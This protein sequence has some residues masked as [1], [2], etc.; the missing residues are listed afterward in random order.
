MLGLKERYPIAIDIA[1]QNIYAA[2][3]QET[4]QGI[5]V[6]ELFYRKLDNGQTDSTEPDDALVPVLKEIAKNKRFRGKS[7]AIHLPAQHVY[8]FPITFEIGAEETLE[9]A[10]VRECRRH[11]SFPLEEAVVDYPSIVDI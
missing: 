5:A 3:F 9:D 10:I 7:V 6:R 2:Q 8:S 11:L 1:D 4:R